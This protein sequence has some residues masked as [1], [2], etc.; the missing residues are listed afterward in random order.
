MRLRA[1]VPRVL[2][3]NFLARRAFAEALAPDCF[4]PDG[5]PNDPSR[6]LFTILLFELQGARPTWAPA[7]LGRLAPRVLQSNWRFYGRLTGL[8]EGERPGV[9]FWRTVTDSRSLAAF[10]LRLARCFPLRRARRMEL[11]HVGDEVR[12]QIDPGE[13][14]APGLVF[15]GRVL[16]EGDVP[17]VLRSRF[18]SFADYGRW[19][20]DQHLSATVWERERVVQEMHLSFNAARFVSVETQEVD[21]PALAECVEDPTQPFSCF[22]AE[23]LEVWLDSIRS[24]PRPQCP[25]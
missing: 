18:T 2:Y 5:L 11:S 4:R 21:I 22:L 9:L 19:I 23:D 17:G 12:A 10:G 3:L 14:Q 20:A 25:Q 16:P 8:P 24:L 1:R 6:T 15:R 7:W 13:G